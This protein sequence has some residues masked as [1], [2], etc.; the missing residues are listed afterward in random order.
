MISTL[1]Y[2]ASRA[3]TAQ[4]RKSWTVARAL[5]VD[6]SRAAKREMGLRVALAE[7]ASG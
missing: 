5:A 4:P 2:P 6:S 3:R 7:T 1:S